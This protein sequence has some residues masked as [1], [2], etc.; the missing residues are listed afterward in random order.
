MIAG[1]AQDGQGKQALDLFCQMHR[2][3]AKPNQFT[4]ASF[5]RACT[6]LVSLEQ[7]MQVHAFASKTGFGLDM[8]VG[9]ALV[10]MYAKCGDI[11]D[12]R[13][14]FDEMLEKNA[15]SW[16]AMIAGYAQNGFVDE[17]LVLFDTM[18][19]RDLVSWNVMIAGYAQCG[20]ADGALELFQKM[21]VKD[22]ISWNAMLAA[23][24]QNRRL[25]EGF[26]FFQKMRERNVVSWNTMIAAYARHN[27]DAEALKL[28]KR[29]KQ[30]SI[31]P[32]QFTVV[33]ILQACSN[34]T[35][36]EHGK[37]IHEEIIRNGFDCTILIGCSLMDMYTKCGC[38]EDAS[39]VFDKM[40]EGNTEVSNVMI[41]GYAR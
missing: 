14:V 2:A 39:K 26:V 7:G 20:Q 13:K 25:E 3:G 30:T 32:D 40:P 15:V 6:G 17:A 36:L 11:E 35:S 4:F 28:F 31:Q 12:A 29:M 34:L 1:Y 8:F 24:T 18:P 27:Q 38:V 16:T 22:A 10:D 23:Y 9:S 21:P 37:E 33:S 5:L 19:E 41:A